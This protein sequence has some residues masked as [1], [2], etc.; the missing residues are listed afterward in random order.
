MSDFNKSDLIL[1]SG[2]GPAGFGAALAFSNNNYKNIISRI[3]LK[4]H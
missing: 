3:L 2:G 1:I 4:F